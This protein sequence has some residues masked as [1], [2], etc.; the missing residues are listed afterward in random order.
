MF[1]SAKEVAQSVHQMQDVW[2]AIAGSVV[3]ATNELID[4]SFPFSDMFESLSMGNELPDVRVPKMLLPF[5]KPVH[6]QLLRH[7][8]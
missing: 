7:L 3:E 6:E 8:R 1:P 4:R 2:Y 5:V